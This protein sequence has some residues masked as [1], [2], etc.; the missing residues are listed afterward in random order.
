MITAYTF[1]LIIPA[2]LVLIVAGCQPLERNDWE[3]AI[4]SCQQR[5]RSI[6]AMLE[7]GRYIPA[8]ASYQRQ[9]FS[10]HVDEDV[11]AILVGV[12]RAKSHSNTD[13]LRTTPGT[14]A[15]RL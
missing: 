3:Q 9:P 8:T 10:E 2:M 5:S 11:A 14:L 4:L 13:R 1:R 15:G 12:Q 6:C 7:S